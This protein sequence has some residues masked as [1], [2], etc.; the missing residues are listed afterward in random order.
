LA[1]LKVL[2]TRVSNFYREQGFPFARAYVPPQAMQ[3]G[4][5]LVINV[6]EGH[7]GKVQAL[8]APDLVAGAQ[9]FLAALVPGTV[10][11]SGPLERV[12]LILDDVPGVRLTPLVR[13]GR[14]TGTGDLEL[15]MERELKMG[16]AVSANNHGNR[17]TG[18][19][20]INVSARVNGVL[21]FGDQ[22]NIQA[23]GSD[24]NLLNGSVSYAAPIGG[25]GLRWQL[26][27]AHT[28][29]QLGEEFRNL[30]ANG[31]AKVTTMG[32]SVPIIRAQ[33]GNLAVAA[34]VQ[35]KELL[36]VQDS[37]STRGEKLSEV[38]P[39]AVTFDLRDGLGGGGVT[40]G[41]L[42]WTSGTLSLD[43]GLNNT[44]KTTAQTAG[45][46]QKATLDLAR[47]QTLFSG[48][49]LYGRVAGQWAEKNLDSSERFG[50]GG[51]SGVRA[52]PSGEGFGDQGALSQLEL[53]YSFEAWAPY[54]FYDAGSVT[55]NSR[56]WT[57]STNV[58]TI[59][60]G[61]LGVR[62]ARNGWTG[63][64][65]VAWREGGGSALSDSRQDIPRVWVTGGYAF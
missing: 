61:G 22:V 47:L 49:T 62:Y 43:R 33:R 4:G 9:P 27:Y 6:V 56:A 38:V 64:V 1:G 39:V 10:I 41:S 29:Y 51:A 14:D 17:Y 53:R 55:T 65:V 63:D 23:S 19:E 25:S 45:G 20:Q 11:E 8:G 37:S 58:R 13:P 34:S 26:G 16:G 54:I 30:R 35:R 57:T 36:D 40:F 5:A 52:Y 24:A 3:Q 60:G 48:F 44:D 2:A 59:S 18:A 15:R 50:L 21:S 12:T 28:F 7:Y 31:T 46:F 42:V 32:L